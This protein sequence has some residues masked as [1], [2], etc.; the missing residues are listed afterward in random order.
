MSTRA[1]SAA[2]LALALGEGAAA[3]TLLVTHFSQN[4]GRRVATVD[5][6]D[7]SLVSVSYLDL[8][9]GGAPVNR[10]EC[11]VVVGDEVWVT[12]VVL[13][14][15][16]R[17]S[18]DGGTYLGDA[19]AGFGDL[20]GGLVRSGTPWFTVGDPGGGARSLL[21]VTPGGVVPHPLTRR[22]FGVVEFQG[23]LVYSHGQG[24]VRVDPDTGAEL[25]DLVAVPFQGEYMQ[26]TV[27]RSS[28]NLLVPRQAGNQDIVEVDASGAVVAEYEV[29][30]SLGI[31]A[32]FAAYELDDGNLLL[33]ADGGLFVVD[34]ALTQATVVLDDVRGR[35]VTEG[36]GAPVGTPFCPV[37]PNTTGRGG[38]LAATG[39]SRAS[40][41]VL[42]LSAH[43][44]PEVSSVL[45]LVS[46]IQD[47]VP[48][49][50]GSQGNLCLASPT[51]RYVTQV[52]WTSSVGF[53]EQ[54]FDLTRIPQANTLVAASAGET[55]HWQAWYRDTVGGAPTSNFTNGVRVTLQ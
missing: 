7:G 20:H 35:L 51:G 31:G 39:S 48:G 36:P 15:V 29:L 52:D 4:G 33:S 12:D 16:H 18:A 34:P 1:L 43:D 21:E 47:F 54:R 6:A 8:T 23:E 28:G 45:Y 49:A 53:S 3:Q 41:N 40:D 11:A 14:T 44:L 9:E 32:V 55:W 30:Q 2:L 19:L 42:R 10:P 38:V 25:G 22:P 50:G 24:L 27:R 26:P 5:R 46:P 17:W 13:E 37:V